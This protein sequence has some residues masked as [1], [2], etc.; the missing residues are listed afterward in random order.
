MQARTPTGEIESLDDAHSI[1]VSAAEQGNCS[2]VLITIASALGALEALDKPHNN[3]NY[4][5]EVR[6]NLNMLADELSQDELSSERVY[7][8]ELSAEDWSLADSIESDDLS[9]DD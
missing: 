2:A 1:L 3:P 9:Y 6:I 5:A 8:G 7:A 4:W